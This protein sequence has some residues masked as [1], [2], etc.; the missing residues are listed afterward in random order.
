MTRTLLFIVTRCSVYFRLFITDN[1]IMTSITNSFNIIELYHVFQMCLFYGGVP[2]FSIA[3]FSTPAFS[4]PRF[5]QERQSIV[6]TFIYLPMEGVNIG[7]EFKLSRILL[8][9]LLSVRSNLSVFGL[10]R[11]YVTRVV[12]GQLRCLAKTIRKQYGDGSTSQTIS[13]RHVIAASIVRL[14]SVLFVIGRTGIFF[15]HHSLDGRRRADSS[16]WD[17]LQP[18]EPT[19]QQEPFEASCVGVK[20]SPYTGTGG[21]AGGVPTTGHACVHTHRRPISMRR[22]MLLLALSV[23]ERPPHHLD[24]LPAGRQWPLLSRTSSG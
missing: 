18:Y 8:A 20:P 19:R 12:D 22:L 5:K 1:L 4:E 13:Y 21:G 3:A 23:R 15:S 24:G 6:S 14:Q 7:A 10:S 2:Y 11:C 16:G 17:K 9:F